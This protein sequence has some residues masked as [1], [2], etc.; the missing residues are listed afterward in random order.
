MLKVARMGG[1]KVLVAEDDKFLRAFVSSKVKKL[2][3]E[4]VTAN[5]GNEALEVMRAGGC[6]VVLLDLIMPNK[7]GFTVL[8]EAKQDPKLSQ[9]PIIVISSL[10]QPEDIKIATDL[11]ARGYF[12]KTSV[13]YGALPKIISDLFAH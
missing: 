12:D 3:F 5:D 9:I 13:D 2:G 4:V 10:E 7:D 11:G 6:E 1:M 8:R